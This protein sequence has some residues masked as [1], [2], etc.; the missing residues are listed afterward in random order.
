MSRDMQT[1]RILEA[2]EKRRVADIAI[3]IPA[4]PFDVRVSVNMEA[5]QTGLTNESLQGWPRVESERVKDRISY[6]FS[7]L[8]KVDLTQVRQGDSVA[9]PGPRHELE[10]ELFKAQA[11]LR[12]DPALTAKFVCSILDLARHSFI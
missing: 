3:H 4:C 12:N 8:L 9:G 5:I 11:Q 2:M 7:D 1:G 6:E 10:V